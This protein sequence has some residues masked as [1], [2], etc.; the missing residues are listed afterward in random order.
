MLLRIIIVVEVS[1]RKQFAQVLG[2]GD[3]SKLSERVF[4]LLGNVWDIRRF[5]ADDFLKLLRCEYFMLNIRVE[6]PAVT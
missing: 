6:N 1:C 4:I 3:I 2:C 5:E